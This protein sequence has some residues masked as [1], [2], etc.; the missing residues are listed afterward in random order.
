MITDNKV[1]KLLHYRI[2]L[3]LPMVY[4][5][6]LS[7]LEF[8]SKVLYKLNETIG[9]LNE[10]ID[11]LDSFIKYVNEFY[12]TKQYVNDKI[13]DAMA[14]GNFTGTIWGVPSMYYPDMRDQILWI[15]EQINGGNIGHNIDDG[16]FTDGDI[17]DN[18][19]GGLW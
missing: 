8:L 5:D 1:S 2:Q 12:A 14:N 15:I 4:D 11:H 19:D 3:V 17:T 18:Y 9:S 16:W 6:S 7:Y 10:V 13:T